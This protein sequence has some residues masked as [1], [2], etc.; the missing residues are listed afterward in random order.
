MVSVKWLGDMAFESTPPSG[1]KFILDSYP[2]TG[3]HSKG[4]T[5]VEALLSS[6]AACSAMDVVSILEK[7]R[8][9]VDSYR[10]EIEGDRAAAGSEW[11]RPFTAIRMKHILT[12]PGLDPAAVARSIQLSEEKYC[13]VLATLR[14]GPPVTSTSEVNGLE[15]QVE[16]EQRVG[17]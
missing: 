13:T 16:E 5:P 1:N 11:P 12:G 6:L 2:E 7:K 14:L 17:N 15:V 9:K 3:G 10:V 4:P 8:Q